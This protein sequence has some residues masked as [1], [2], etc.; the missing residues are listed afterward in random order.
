M[1]LRNTSKEW[2]IVGLT[3]LFSL[4][5]IFSS[6]AIWASSAKNIIMKKELLESF[7][8]I[9]V[10]FFGC[11]TIIAQENL[12]IY[13]GEFK[14]NGFGFGGWND[15]KGVSTYHYRESTDG[16][17]IFEGEFSFEKNTGYNNNTHYNVSG[18]FKNNKQV[19]QW[20]WSCSSSIYQHTE[21]CETTINFDDNSVP[22]G[23]F[24]SWIGE[25]ERHR[26]SWMYCEFENGKII[27]ASYKDND[28]IFARGK[29]NSKGL[30]TGKWYVS[31]RG[32]KNRSCTFIYDAI[33]NCLESYYIDE[34]TGDKIPVV[35]EYP[36]EI[37]GIIISS[38][39]RL[40]FRS[41]PPI[42]M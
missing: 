23:S 14:M 24:E 5:Q 30:P 3:S 38:V 28:V 34:T 22:C 33:G 6:S 1:T 8:I 16:T 2:K 36:Y 17:R 15:I 18:C 13:N 26:R 19:G 40:C 21:V 9:I 29:F 7:I 35:S 41:T 10:T 4:K 25:G 39:R 11:Q 32:V 27:S 20:K 42:K 37:Y 31:G 12:R